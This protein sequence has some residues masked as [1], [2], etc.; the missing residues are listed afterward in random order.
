MWGRGTKVP[1][2]CG[3]A[4]LS[5]D[6]GLGRC[7]R[8]CEHGRRCLVSRAS[9]AL[10]DV[11]PVWPRG[12]VRHQT[13]CGRAADRVGWCSR[14]A[15]GGRTTGAAGL[16]CDTE[17]GS[18]APHAFDA[19]LVNA[20]R[21]NRGLCRAAVGRMARPPGAHRRSPLPRIHTDDFRRGTPVLTTTEPPWWRRTCGAEPYQGTWSTPRDAR[22]HDHP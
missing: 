6:L 19:E 16:L 1:A 17:R 15:S 12:L 9:R 7:C 5:C 11:L 8:W 21:A 2:P 13:R 4:S 10:S 22:Q 3:R 14:H 18:R 20:A